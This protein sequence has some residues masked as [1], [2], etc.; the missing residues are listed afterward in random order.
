MQQEH[1][2]LV[3]ARYEPYWKHIYTQ[4]QCLPNV[5]LS[6][7]CT[8]HAIS[9]AATMTDTT[10]RVTTTAT[11]TPM[12]APEL[13]LGRG[14]PPVPGGSWDDVSTLVSRMDDSPATGSWPD[15][16]LAARWDKATLVGE[17]PLDSVIDVAVAEDLGASGATDVFDEIELLVT[18]GTAHSKH[19]SV[20]KSN[21]NEELGTTRMAMCIQHSKHFVYN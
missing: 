4:S 9:T 3:H 13:L 19:T 21:V 1:G 16:Q 12:I 14:P 10:T 7:Q 11:T 20:T 2:A 5:F 6:L 15:L 8:L 18:S 17:T